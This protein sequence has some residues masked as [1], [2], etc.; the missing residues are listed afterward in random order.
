MYVVG[1]AGH[2]DH[3]KTL[4]VK[5]LTGIDCDRLPEEK[6]RQMTID[7]GF[8]QMELPGTGTASVIDV[9]GHERFIRNMVSGAWGI[10]L[11]LLI[12]AADDGWMPQT[13]DH[14]R[15]LQ[16]L[17]VKRIIAVINKID[18]AGPDDIALLKTRIRE[19]LSGTPYENAD[20]AEASARRGDG[21]EGLRGLI[22]ENLHALDVGG[23]TGKPYLF[24][25]RVFAVKG[26]G[27]VVTGTLRNGLFDENDTVSVLPGN[28]TARV[29][30][31]E[32][33]Y[34]TVH[35]TGALRAALNLS[36]L[37]LE[38]AAR[39]DIVVRRSFFTETD[40]FIATLEMTD[41]GESRKGHRGVEVLI[42]TAGLPARI[43]SIAA[44]D[45]RGADGIIRIKLERPWPV[46]P[47]QRF[48]LTKTGGHHIFGGGAVILADYGRERDRKRARE[49]AA[50]IG[51]PDAEGILRYAIAVPGWRSRES[52][53]RM[54]EYGDDTLEAMLGSL[55]NRGLI[56][57]VENYYFSAD[58]AESVLAA[59]SGF[60]ASS[61]GVNIREIADA[62]GIGQEPCGALVKKLCADGALA[63]RQGRYFGRE[64]LAAPEFSRDARIILER[65]RS[66][67][68][69]G[70]EL[71]SAAN[72]KEKKAMKELLGL[73]QLVSMD[74]S[75]LW[76]RDYYDETKKLILKTL[77]TKEKLAVSDARG[78]TGLSR[79]FLLPL[80][81]RMERD[82]LVK[83]LGDFRVKT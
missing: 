19:R 44:A 64:A 20:I 47:G 6:E 55:A 24:V 83:R 1:T 61:S 5:A 51:K 60:V 77:E 25:D 23:D 26:H 29:K 71:S 31:M 39:G 69:S 76:H 62:S 68:P 11:G 45:T 14:F 54:F 49:L 43:N 30:R 66:G 8:A 34:R 40:D 22:A 33:H 28:R 75:L 12:V 2:I 82:G 50:E 63:E 9:P 21:I 17:S 48:I 79:K 18:L 36:G 16:L 27:T 38:D 15:V 57:R 32:S 78:A 65:A 70:V 4:L 35:E 81:N 72:D 10:D 42:G 80:L 74:G 37:S 67:G 13:E 59:I 56:T 58:L 3:G 46:F 7:L 52:L 73:G 53:G 41:P